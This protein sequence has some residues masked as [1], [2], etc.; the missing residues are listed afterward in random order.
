VSIV[1]DVFLVVLLSMAIGYGFILNRRIV[2]LRKDQ[3]NLDKLANKFAEA[4]VRAEQSIYKL[5][6]TTDAA[7]MALEETVNGA[8]TVRDDLEFL[9]DR[10][11]RLADILETDI[12][13]T[14]KQKVAVGV[15]AN[16]NAKAGTDADVAGP[17][18][19]SPAKTEAEREL[20]RALQAV[21]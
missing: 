2:A 8:N 12:R 5:K 3:K 9:I 21:R 10:G 7:S 17:L 16:G 6:S 20:I 11:N 1:L 18:K 19:D 13:Q 4:T 15:S 14:E